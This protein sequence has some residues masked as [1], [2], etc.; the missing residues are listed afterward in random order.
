VCGWRVKLCDPLVTHGPY[1][2][3][4]AVVLPIIRRYTNIQI[5]LALTQWLKWSARSGG[6]LPRPFPSLYPPPSPVHTAF[7]SCRHICFVFCVASCSFFVAN[8]FD[9]V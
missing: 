5:T 2:S 3:A 4:V 6:S 7:V 8:K 1:L 9:L